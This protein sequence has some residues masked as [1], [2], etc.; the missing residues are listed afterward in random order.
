MKNLQVLTPHQNCIYNCPF[1]IAKSHNH[2]NNFENNY[3]KNYKLWKNNLI[4][5]IITNTDLKYVIITGTNEPMQSK[6]CIKDII[7]IVRSVNKNIQIEIQTRYYGQ[8]EIFNIVDVVAYSISKPR[9]LNKIK[10]MGKIQRYVLILTDDFNNYKLNEI[11]NLIPKSVNQLTFKLLEDSEGKNIEFDNY[12]HSHRI[13]KSTLEKLRED[14]N[15][16]KGNISIRLDEN[17]MNS[18]NRYMIFREDG[19]IY[20][21]WDDYEKSSEK[22]YRKK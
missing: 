1:C 19:N 7:N 20:E 13:D 21:S 12:I 10:P 22:T 6:A 2:L 16:Y 5:T 9:V 17:C 15:N 11:L 4:Y 14:I 8:D 18:I 3:E